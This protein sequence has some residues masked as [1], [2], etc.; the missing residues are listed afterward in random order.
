MK[1]GPFTTCSNASIIK[2]TLTMIPYLLPHEEMLSIVWVSS[3]CGGCCF[4]GEDEWCRVVDGRG[5]VFT[6]WDL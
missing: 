4:V 1:R 2:L 3:S 5:S 6:M